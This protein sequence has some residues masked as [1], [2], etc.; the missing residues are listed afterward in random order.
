MLFHG[1]KQSPTEDDMLKLTVEQHQ[2]RIAGG[3]VLE[4]DGLGPK[5]LALDDGTMAK[6]FRRREGLTSDKLRPYSLRFM[7]NAAKLKQAGI[8]TLTPLE[9]Y[10]VIGESLDVV[11]YQPLP[12][13]S[14]KDLCRDK[15]EQIDAKL[16]ADFGQ[17][18]AKLH[19][20]G[21]LFRS[22]HLGNVLKTDDSQFGLIDIADLTIDTL[23]LSGA[24]RLRNFKH[25]VRMGEY[26]TPI[27]SHAETLSSAY[28]NDYP[29]AS[30]KFRSQLQKL[31]AQW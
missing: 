18:I 17:Y 8:A 6:L 23:K 15:P 21:I 10:R 30:Q 29:A 26:K 28:L 20:Q 27:K 4:A 2:T 31:I 5:V 25:L 24:Q 16:A 3:K 7:R 9:R 12:G 14:L 13:T 1:N 19:S 11:I 22:L